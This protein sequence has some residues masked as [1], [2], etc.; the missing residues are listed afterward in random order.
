MPVFIAAEMSDGFHARAGP[1][2][3]NSD[4]NRLLCATV[5]RARPPRCLSPA[6]TFK[7]IK[8][9]PYPSN[10]SHARTLMK[11]IRTIDCVDTGLQTDTHASA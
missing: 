2:S 6:V 7:L 10:E 11:R 9:M 8:K 1:V 4:H 3:P 5:G